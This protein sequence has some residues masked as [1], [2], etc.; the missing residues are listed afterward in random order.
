MPRRKFPKQMEVIEPGKILQLWQ[1]I[2]AFVE[3]NIRQVSAIG[4]IIVVIAGGIGLW[5]YRLA[6]AEDQAQ[7]LFFTAL[8][9]YNSPDSPAAKG[10]PAPVKEDAYRQALEEFKKITQQYPD[11]EGGVAALFYM[12]GCSYRLGKV[13]DALTYYQ[14][15]L[16]KT[17]EI[18]TRL[19]PLA[20]EGIGYAYERKSDYKKALE[21]FEKQDKDT[22]GGLNIMAP[23]NLARCYAA[24]GDREHACKSYQAFLDK[25]PSSYFAETAKTGV[26][27]QCG[28]K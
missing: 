3:E 21:W 19:R 14:N 2:Q 27:E 22:G 20:Y 28:K 15:F 5:K 12:G 13:D 4:L 23:L 1:Q 9:R 18:D 24:L 16:K 17:G 26:A 10:G 11:T 7:T 25:N 6:Q 8:N